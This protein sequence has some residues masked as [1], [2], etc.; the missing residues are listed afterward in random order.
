MPSPSHSP[1]TR[2]RVL[3]V[4]DDVRLARE[5]NLF[6]ERKGLAVQV[7][8][9]GEGVVAAAATADLVVLDWMLPGVDGLTICRVLRASS[10]VPILF[11]TAREGDAAEVQALQEGA[12]DY[13]SKPVRPE[14]LLARIEALLRRTFGR[15][16][17]GPRDRV[18]V[19]RL[20]LDAQRRTVELAGVPVDLTDAEYVL[21][22][23]L[24]THAGTVV[25]RDA[26]SL[27]LTGRPY[28]GLSRR[29]DQYIVR[30]RR[31]LGD[32]GKSPQLLKTVRGG[33]YLL[34]GV[35]EG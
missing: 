23:M 11:L 26:L 25:S 29:V 14:V 22:T 7:L 1:G 30:L 20:Q 2:P 18:R 27:R 13:L 10:A 5:V 4:E 3:L 19:G 9:R 35:R 32:D 33:G 15:G 21:L 17:P 12:D 16:K 34:A 8:H 31:K 24:M 28:D 6:L